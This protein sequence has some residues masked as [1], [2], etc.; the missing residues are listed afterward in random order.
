[1][2]IESEDFFDILTAALVIEGTETLDLYSG[3]SIVTS[4]DTVD[5]TGGSALTFSDPTSSL[6]GGSFFGVEFATSVLSLGGHI[7]TGNLGAPT[8]P[9]TLVG[10]AAG[11]SA[12]AATASNA[13]DAALSEIKQAFLPSRVPQHEPWPR[14]M[15]DPDSTDQDAD[16]EFVLEFTSNDDANIGRVE[17]GEEIPRND[18]WHR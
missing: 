14:V 15:M 4:G 7:H 12:T 17:L 3:G 2:V 16:N 9:G 5:I 8:T 1:M 10:G 13:L 11:S 6:A 18:N